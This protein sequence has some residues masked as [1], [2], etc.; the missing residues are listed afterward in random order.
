MLPQVVRDIRCERA[1]RHGPNHVLCRECGAALSAG[2]AP[3]KAPEPATTVSV[4]GKK[5]HIVWL[6]IVGV[7]LVGTYVA[8]FIPAFAGQKPESAAFN[9]CVLWTTCFFWLWWK[10]QGRKGWHGGLIGF[11]VG[12]MVGVAAQVIFRMASAAAGS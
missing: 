3:T 6:Y 7:F 10:R 8:T 2:P 1:P 5:P 11:G 12:F 4:T 9:G